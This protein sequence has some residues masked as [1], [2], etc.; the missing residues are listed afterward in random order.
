[1]KER[2]R[3]RERERKKRKEGGG[4]THRGVFFSLSVTLMSAP[5]SR[6]FSIICV[7]PRA[8][9]RCSGVIPCLSLAFTFTPLVTSWPKS[10]IFIPQPDK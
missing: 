6:S 9:A 10:C 1:M 4:E 2:E 3:E 5:D 7:N 8:A